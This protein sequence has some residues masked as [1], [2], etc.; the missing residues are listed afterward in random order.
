MV[1]FSFSVHLFLFLWQLFKFICSRFRRSV[2]SCIS[3]EA[4]QNPERKK[5]TTLLRKLSEKR[6]HKYEL[7]QHQHQLSLTKSSSSSSSSLNNSFQNNKKPPVAEGSSTTDLSEMKPLTSSSSSPYFDESSS[8][9]SLFQPANF[10]SSS[11]ASTASN[12]PVNISPSH[13]DGYIIFYIF[14]Y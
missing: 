5:K 14:I 12:S 7:L 11:A 9:S 1:F 8:S 10:Y 2:G 4:S 6:A 13:R 3:T